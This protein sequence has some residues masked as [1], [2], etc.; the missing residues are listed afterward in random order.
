M[1]ISTRLSRDIPANLMLALFA[2]GLSLK[3]FCLAQMKQEWE[4]YTISS[5]NA[6]KGTN[7]ETP[8]LALTPYAT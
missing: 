5:V 8:Q 6:V 1:S 4:Y 7:A 3:P 2:T